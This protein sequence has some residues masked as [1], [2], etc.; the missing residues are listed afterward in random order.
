MSKA[1]PEKK[2]LP[3]RFYA[4]AKMQQNADGFC[5][6]LDG[7]LLRTQGRN[8]LQLHHAEIAA[9]I[10]AEWEAQ[11]PHI[12]PDTMPLTRLI[13]LALDRAAIDR[14][15]WLEEI[16]RYGETDLLCY[17]AP[18]T[19]NS[20]L[21]GERDVRVHSRGGDF[22]HAVPPTE[23]QVRFDSPSGGEL[24]AKQDASFTPILEWAA[25]QGVRLHVTEGVMPVA[26]S[27][28][29]LHTLRMLFAAA[30]DGELAALAMLTPLLGS[31]LLTL[32]LWK[33]KITVGDALIACRLDEDFQAAQWG[34][35]EEAAKA[36]AAKRRDTQ[37]A[38]FFLDTQTL[39]KP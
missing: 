28:E 16:T 10:A 3:K 4:A 33:C 30:T 38:A 17:R 35:D 27:A 18:H 24:R 6:T 14:D 23:S 39:K 19:P 2:S 7:K 22:P 32:A 21:K 13:N 12:D 11:G 9:A 25:G 15:A 8:M 36:W 5:I 34:E 29:S 37:A 1:K 31:A 20:P 26:Q